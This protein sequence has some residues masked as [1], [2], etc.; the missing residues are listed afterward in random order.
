M[1]DRYQSNVHQLGAFDAEEML[2]EVRALRERV[3][4]VW[5]ERAVM[6]TPDEQQQLR[7]EIQDTCTLLTDLTK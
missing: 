6:L 2:A 7:R 5:R 1:P 4:A 3:I